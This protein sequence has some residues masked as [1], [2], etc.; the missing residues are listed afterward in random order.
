MHW[1]KDHKFDIDTVLNNIIVKPIV[2]KRALAMILHKIIINNLIYT[3]I[4]KS[5]V[6]IFE[7]NICSGKSIKLNKGF[8]V[9]MSTKPSVNVN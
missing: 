4:S 9:I 2:S 8:G 7:S 1:Y 3:K 5:Y 6:S